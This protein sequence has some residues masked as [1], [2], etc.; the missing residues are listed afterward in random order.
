MALGTA[1]S[2]RAMARQGIGPATRLVTLGSPDPLHLS[3]RLFAAFQAG[4][5]GVPRLSVL[6]PLGALVEALNAYRP[7]AIVGYPTVATLLA[8]EQLE[9]RLDIAPRILAFGS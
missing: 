7:E 3:R 6:T 1:V 4:R 9:G 8:A 5:Q 2:L